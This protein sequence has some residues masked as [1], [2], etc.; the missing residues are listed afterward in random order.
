M[1][2]SYIIKVAEEYPLKQSLSSNWSHT[3]DHADHRLYEDIFWL[4]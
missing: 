3:A 2:E 1:G 4:I